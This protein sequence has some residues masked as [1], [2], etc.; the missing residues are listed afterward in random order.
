MF[1]PTVAL[2]KSGIVY[3]RHDLR[4]DFERVRWLDGARL[5]ATSLDI[6]NM[7]LFEYH[8]PISSQIVYIPIWTSSPI[9]LQFLAIDTTMKIR[10]HDYCTWQIVILQNSKQPSYPYC[11]DLRWAWNISRHKQ[12]FNLF[13]NRRE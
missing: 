5:P 3:R 4:H 2:T 10:Q 12:R 7:N 1:G 9:S 11:P 13:I 8:S 6:P